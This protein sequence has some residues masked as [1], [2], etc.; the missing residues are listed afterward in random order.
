M[1]SLFDIAIANLW[2]RLWRLKQQRLKS[3]FVLGFLVV[4][5]KITRKPFYIP[6]LKR[7]EHTVIVGKTGTGKSYLLFFE[8]LQ[9]IKAGRTV[10]L[11]DFHGYGIPFLLSAMAAEEKQSGKNLAGKVVVIA[12]GDPDW[13]VGLN[14]L[15]AEGEQEIFNQIAVFTAILRERF[16]IEHFGPRTEELLRN[17]LFALMANGLTLVELGPFLANAALRSKCL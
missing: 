1:T 13:A 12:P 11:F 4:D 8:A 17:S 16:G 3:G 7:I 10:I 14:V 15:A 2:N 6:N 5:G 9:D